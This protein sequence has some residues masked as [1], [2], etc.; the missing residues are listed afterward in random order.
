MA[1]ADS[2]STPSVGLQDDASVGAVSVGHSVNPV[3]ARLPVTFGVSF[4]LDFYAQYRRKARSST[5][6]LRTA[7]FSLPCTTDTNSTASGPT[8]WQY[9][10]AVTTKGEGFSSQELFQYRNG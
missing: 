3:I 9:T 4:G 10:H 5:I 2:H 6:A 1:S 7:Q 8:H